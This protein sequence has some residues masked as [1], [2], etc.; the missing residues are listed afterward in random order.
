MGN[1]M[2]RNKQTHHGYHSLQPT[3]YS[4]VSHYHYRYHSYPRRR[5]YAY[6]HY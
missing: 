1:R 2:G 6:Y 4:H 3:G 5:R